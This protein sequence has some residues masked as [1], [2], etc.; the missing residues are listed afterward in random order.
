MGENFMEILPYQFKKNLPCLTAIVLTYNHVGTI[1]NCLESLLEQKQ[2][3]FNLKIVLLDDCSNDGTSDICRDFKKSFPKIFLVIPEKNTKGR[4][5][6]EA[7]YNLNSKYFCFIDGDD[8]YLNKSFFSEAIAFLEENPRFSVYAQDTLFRT[9]T[10]TYSYI[11]EILPAYKRRASGVVSIENYCPLHP[12]SRVMR[13]LYEYGKDWEGTLLSDL[14]L[15]IFNL[16]KSPGYLELN[17]KAGM[18]NWSG[19][20]YFSSLTSRQ[21]LFHK[22]MSWFYVAKKL[23]YHQFKAI[24]EIMRTENILSDRFFKVFSF[25]EVLPPFAFRILIPLFYLRSWKTCLHCTFESL[26]I[27]LSILKKDM[28]T[29]NKS[30]KRFK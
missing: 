16:S 23:N 25:F 11:L 27:N 30:R 8:Q 10:N 3:N 21:Q 26:R 18:Y 9:P 20:G 7:I 14:P 29:F 19:N 1:R 15:L 28:N 13:R 6:Q 24:K 2:D 4:L 22:Y 12:C 17:K 5:F